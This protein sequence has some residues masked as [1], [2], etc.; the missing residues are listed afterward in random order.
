VIRSFSDGRTQRLFQDGKKRGFT[1]L[2][3]QRALLLL[4]AL[5]AAASL[6]SLRVLRAVRLHALTGDRK[7]RYAM[8]VNHRWR[9]TFS[10]AD[11]EAQDV[12]IEDYHR[13]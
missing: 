10:F 13:G 3:Y 6:D 2:D 1:G 4:D 5:D 9:I 12:A 8:T 7:G 11:G